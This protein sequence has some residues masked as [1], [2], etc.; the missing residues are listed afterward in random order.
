[1]GVPALALRICEIASAH[2]RAVLHHLVTAAHKLF[3]HD[4]QRVGGSAYAYA[5][6]QENDTVGC[7]TL[8][9]QL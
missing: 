6:T 2:H 1:M 7:K 5:Y 4:L 9:K 8:C 3:W